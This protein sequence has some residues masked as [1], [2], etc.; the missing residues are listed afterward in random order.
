M[1]WMPNEVYQSTAQAPTALTVTP[2]DNNALSATLTW[3]NP[4][5]FIN[6]LS[7][8]S[9]DKIVVERNGKIIHEESNP[10]AGAAMTYVDNN[11]PCFSFFDYTVY[12]VINGEMGNMNT[13]KKVQFGPTCEWKLILQSS[14]FQG[15]KGASVSILDAAGIEFENKTTA[16]ST[17]TTFDIDVPLGYVQFSWNPHA[18]TQPAYT[19][20]L[21]IKNTAGETVYNYSGSSDEMASGVF[22]TTHNTCGNAT[23]CEA[24]SNLVAST[25]DGEMKLSWTAAG[26]PT[27]GYNVYRD[28]LLVGLTQETTFVDED[29]PY[30]G[31]CYQ[32]TALCES[33]NSEFSN[34]ACGVLTEGCD[35]ASSLR[36]E[37]TSNFKAKLHWTKPNNSDLSGFYIYRKTGDDGEWTRVKILGANK[38][39]YTDNSSLT[40]DTWYFYKVVAYYQAIDC[41][42]APAK[43]LYAPNE[44]FVKFYYSETGIEDV[45][46]EKV[47]I[48]PNPADEQITIE[49]TNIE[50]VTIFNMMGQKVYES[51]VNT[52]NVVLNMS[53]FNAGMYM[54][55]VKTADFE[56]TQRISVVH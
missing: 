2:A 53:D 56:T 4:S 42:S 15:M 5:K 35:P 16:T 47:A 8:S 9:I 17:A 32:V 21:V 41:M 37:K 36:F 3:T 45:T 48:Y 54:I 25:S 6:G 28:G 1:N 34:E 33:G 52:D 46:V 27:Y 49:A 10:S 22:F 12:A 11:V 44:Y 30:G 19:L 14:A 29:M 55:N 20:N 13:V 31:H 26:N 39:D 50:N 7:I 24:P 38:E 18:E 51:S 40:Y 23:Q 43:A